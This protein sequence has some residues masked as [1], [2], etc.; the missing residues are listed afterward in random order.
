MRQE[1]RKKEEERQEEEEEVEKGGYCKGEEGVMLLEVLKARGTGRDEF[2][3]N[4]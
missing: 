1:Q 4:Q 3:C 2:M